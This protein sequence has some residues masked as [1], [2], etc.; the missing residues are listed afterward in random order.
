MH[1]RPVTTFP[2]LVEKSPLRA[3]LWTE[4]TLSAFANLPAVYIWAPSRRSEDGNTA[5]D[6]CIY[7]RKKLKE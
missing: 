7:T 1:I 3:E 4:L 6:T 5:Y 2:S